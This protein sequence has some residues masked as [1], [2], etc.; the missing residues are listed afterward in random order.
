[1]TPTRRQFLL[2]TTG[3]ITA[4]AGCSVLSNPQQSLLVAVNN[5]T[6]TRHHGHV[7]I[8]KD[9]SEVVRQYVEIAAA[10]PDGW[11][12]V[13][14]RIELGEM[15]SGTRLDVTASF[16]DGLNTNGPLTLDCSDEYNGDAIYVQIEKEMN[17]RL[18][19]ACYEE[20]PSD[21]ASQGGLNQS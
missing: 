15:P 21:E 6:D 16:G 14:T 2:A 4:F 7:L 13:E 9:G 19:E 12:T 20:F 3:G 18:N 10:E 5:Y 17:V 11:T 8:E 1:M